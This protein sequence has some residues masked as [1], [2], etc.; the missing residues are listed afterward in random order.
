MLA[1]VVS[2][3]ATTV[4]FLVGAPGAHASNAA[5]E[6]ELAV[7]TSNARAAAGLPGFVSASDLAAVAAGQAARMAARRAI[8]H[9]PD[10]GTDVTGWQV[11]GE[12][13]GAGTDADQV[14]EAFM[15]SP[16]HRDNILSSTFTEVGFG[17]AVGDDGRLYIAEVFRLPATDEAPVAETPAQGAPEPVETAEPAAPAPAPAPA[18]ALETAPA[19]AAPTPPVPT[20][21]VRAAATV[22]A[23]DLGNNRPTLVV[24]Y[25]AVPPVPRAALSYMVWVAALLAQGVLIAHMMVFW[26][27][28]R[29]GSGW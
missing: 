15:N 26:R 13:V 29:I 1:A 27:R 22:R 28:Y 19:L 7:L 25:T 23:T 2:V 4:A 6:N 14:H 20:P 17:T 24:S 12:N 10:L 21:A 5:A 9:N 18:P 16:T 11:V 3:V 8:Y